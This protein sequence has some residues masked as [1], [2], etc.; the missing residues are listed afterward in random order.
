MTDLIQIEPGVEKLI[1]VLVAEVT[2]S[3]QQ[4]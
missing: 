3:L 2:T 4:P 1:I